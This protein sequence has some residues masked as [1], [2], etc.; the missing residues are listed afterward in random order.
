MEGFLEEHLLII[1][2]SEK[3]L[4]EI[5]RVIFTSRYRLNSK[6]KDIFSV[7][8][9]TMIYSIWE[10]FIQKS[11]SLYVT[12]IN[13][14]NMKYE[15]LND[16]LL[17]LC[18]ETHFKQLY[19]YPKDNV[20]RK[21]KFYNDLRDFYGK[22]TVNLSASVN[23]ESNVSFDVMNRLLSQFHL[24]KFPEYWPPRYKY[25]SNL[26]QTMLDFLRYR[27]GIAHGGDLTSEEK[28]TQEVFNKYKRLVLDLMNEINNKFS[29]AISNQTYLKIPRIT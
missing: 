26:K 14:L 7:H 11:F 21:I 28:V 4:N 3:V 12:Y 13:N 9:I 15:D 19:E 18:M 24:E 23:T 29:L 22:E 16:G 8:T 17:V 20:K 1:Q 27:N 10:G 5:E 25:P 6:H 2:E